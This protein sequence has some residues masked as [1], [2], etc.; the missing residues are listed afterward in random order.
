MMDPNGND[1]GEPPA[2]PP[3]AGEVVPAPLTERL[4]AAEP[5]GADARAPRAPV[6]PTVVDDPLPAE[7]SPVEPWA[8]QG[9]TQPGEPPLMEDL[10]PPPNPPRGAPAYYQPAPAYRG[11]L[12]ATARPGMSREVIWIAVLLGGPLLI[13]AAVAAVAV[14]YRT[15]SDSRP[16]PTET[17]PPPA[18]TVAPQ[19]VAPTVQQPRPV[20][21]PPPKTTAT[22]AV[23][24]K[25]KASAQ[26]KATVEPKAT[27]EPQATAEP[28]ATGESEPTL[29]PKRP[30]RN[31][32]RPSDMR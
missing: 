18:T 21:S 5:A 17:S 15:I 7:S 27:A 29:E 20:V 32:P 4:K 11:P 31:R 14:A 23:K 19:I 2:A 24:P 3:P 9:R 26:P 16:L 22:S 10:A 6:S 8:A 25:P 1:P 30:G 12:P 28:E 13:A